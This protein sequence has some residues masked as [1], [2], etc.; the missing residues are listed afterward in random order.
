MSVLYRRSGPED[1]PQVQAFWREHWGGDVM[2]VHGTLYRPAQLEGFVASEG[3][4]W[5]GLITYSLLGNACEIISLDSLRE[6]EGIGSRL[7]EQVAAEAR[8]AGC[9]RLF[10]STTNDNLR[11]LGF[12][13]RRGFVLAAVRPGAVNASRQIKPSI[14]LIGLNNIPLRDEIELEMS[15]S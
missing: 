11:A 5:V 6:G 9:K 2:L 1:I 4:A 10:L 15:L 8:R 13:Q 14:P 12:Y 7:I 3:D